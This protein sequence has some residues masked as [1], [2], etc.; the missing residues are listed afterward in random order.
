[1]GCGQSK[2]IHLY[3]RKNKSKSNGKKGHGKRWQT[4]KKYSIQFARK[5]SRLVSL[6]KNYVFAVVTLVIIMMICNFRSQEGKK[7][8]Q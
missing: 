3:P 2:K 5:I 8:A 4:P 1:M 6:Q 7:I